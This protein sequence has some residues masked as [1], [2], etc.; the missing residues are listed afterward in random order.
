MINSR[1]RRLF[2][3]S[4]SV[5]ALAVTPVFA[6]EVG[7]VSGIIAKSQA[8]GADYVSVLRIPQGIVNVFGADVVSER[9]VA[10]AAV[11]R[12]KGED[13]GAIRQLVEVEYGDGGAVLINN[14]DTTIQAVSLAS[15][16]K[17]RKDIL[18]SSK[19]AYGVRQDVEVDEGRSVDLS[20]TNNNAFSVTSSAT[21]AFALPAHGDGNAKHAAIAVVGSGT[22]QHADA[23][24]GGNGSV[25][26]TNAKTAVAGFSAEAALA[27]TDPTEG[28]PAQ[29]GNQ[30]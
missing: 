26:L 1:S 5:L 14:G 3:A 30:H 22:V 25:S 21:G 24:E 12:V 19:I 2:A 28:N 11:N 10:E 4:T 15:S 7:N 27:P 13:G 29:S 9:G 20:I 6:D 8:E 16:E 23:H 18:A 17:P